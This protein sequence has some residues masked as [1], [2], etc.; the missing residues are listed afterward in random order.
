M[1]I[2]KGIYSASLTLISKD[3]TV[4]VDETIKHSERLLMNGATGCVIFGST[5]Q[6]QLIS[7]DEKKKVIEKLADSKFKDR[8]ILGT[9]LNSLNENINLIKLLRPVPRIKRSL[10][11]LSASFSITFFFSSIEIN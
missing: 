6:A 2:K 9:G 10:N 5:G 1:S 8:F 11:L 7:I 4:D 3:M